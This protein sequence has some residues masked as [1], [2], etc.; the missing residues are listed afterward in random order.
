VEPSALNKKS[1]SP[2]TVPRGSGGDNSDS[3]GRGNGR[4][5]KP[6]ESI[7][8]QNNNNQDLNGNGAFDDVMVYSKPGKPPSSSSSSSSRTSPDKVSNPG[9][10]GAAVL[11]PYKADNNNIDLNAIGEVSDK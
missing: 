10:Q 2:I 11:S 6:W 8:D 7:S 3:A 5:S 4:A 9:Q 1:P